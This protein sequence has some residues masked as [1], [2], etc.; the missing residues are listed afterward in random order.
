MD[1]SPSL[2]EMLALPWSDA[3]RMAIEDHYRL[4]L[5]SWPANGTP[6]PWELHLVEKAETAVYE[7]AFFPE[8]N[9][10]K[11]FPT[12]FIERCMWV[13]QSRAD[14]AMQG[15]ESRSADAHRL[16]EPTAAV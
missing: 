1:A 6:G 8:W 12:G 14:S 13:T 15:D 16:N 9:T 2:A 3:T 4:I 10:G 5:K 7:H 11:P